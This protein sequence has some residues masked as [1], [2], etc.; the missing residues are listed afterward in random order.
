MK[1]YFLPDKIRPKLQVAWGL[2]LYGSVEEVG[3]QYSKFMAKK[4]Y[5]RVVTVGDFCSLHLASDVKIFDR[6]VQRQAFRH[7]FTCAKDVKNAPGTVQ[8]E[9]WPIVKDAI[10]NKTNV[11]VDGEEDLLVI[12]AVLESGDKNLVV[13]GLPNKG[14]SLLET[15]AKTKKTFRNFLRKNF[16]TRQ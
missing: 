8:K 10:K 16:E 13:Y 4:K 3:L 14:V 15:T 6:K 12:P 9:T 5:R 2:P 1:T 7:D 11:C